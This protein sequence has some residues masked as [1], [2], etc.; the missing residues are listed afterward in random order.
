[1][2]RDGKERIGAG[3]DDGEREGWTGE[4]RGGQSRGD[5]EQYQAWMHLEMTRLQVL[6]RGFRNQNCFVV[7]LSHTHIH[8]RQVCRMYCM[9]MTTTHADAV[10]LYL[11]GSTF[12]YM[13]AI[14]KMF[15]PF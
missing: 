15:C 12:S 14:F 7:S 2:K 11:I 9:H 3:R 8:N 10:S 4:D 1:M 13:I 6:K 5:E